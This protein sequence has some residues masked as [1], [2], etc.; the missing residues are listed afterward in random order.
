[1]DQFGHCVSPGAKGAAANQNIRKTTARQPVDLDSFIGNEDVVPPPSIL[2]AA[3]AVSTNETGDHN[4][5]LQVIDPP[6]RTVSTSPKAPFSE[7]TV[8]FR[9]ALIIH[10]SNTAI[11]SLPTPGLNMSMEKANVGHNV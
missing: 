8:K 5:A 4:R 1:M 7:Q 3:A 11:P 6:P 9:K 10:G 2:S